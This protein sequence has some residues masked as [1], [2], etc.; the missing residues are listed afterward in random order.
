MRIFAGFLD[1][2]T[3]SMN[4]LDVNITQR[5]LLQRFVGGH[6]FAGSCEYLYTEVLKSVANGDRFEYFMGE[7]CDP[8]NPS[9][10]L[11]TE[12]DWLVYLLKNIALEAKSE[13][14]RVVFLND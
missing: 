11:G 13:N 5:S 4:Y 1:S 8:L 6:S 9:S 10:M 2:Q 12:F 14:S 7:A 3:H